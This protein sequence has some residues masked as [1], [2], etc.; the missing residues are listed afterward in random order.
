MRNRGVAVRSGEAGLQVTANLARRGAR[1]CVREVDQ[2][3]NGVQGRGNQRA[4]RAVDAHVNSEH[5]VP[6][7]RSTLHRAVAVRARAG[8]E[9]GIQQIRLVLTVSGPDVDGAI[10]DVT[11]KLAKLGRSDRGGRT[12]RMSRGRCRAGCRGSGC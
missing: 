8:L 2:I 6:S 1:E 7:N 9:D 10:N 4:G 5:I 3:G 12:G 11:L